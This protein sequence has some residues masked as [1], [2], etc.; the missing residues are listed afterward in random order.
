M[1]Y[2]ASAKWI[3]SAANQDVAGDF[4]ENGYGLG[5]FKFDLAPEMF[6]SSE[7][8]IAIDFDRW[9]EFTYFIL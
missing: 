3:E 6:I 5:G 9:S 7:T 2:D 1:A 8:S 4:S